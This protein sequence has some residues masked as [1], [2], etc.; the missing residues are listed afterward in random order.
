MNIMITGSNS[1]LGLAMALALEAEGHNVIPF[2]IGGGNDVRRANEKK[3]SGAVSMYGVDSLDVLINNAGVN[4]IAWLEDV[5]DDDWDEVMGVN[6]KGIYKMTQACLPLLKQSKGTVIN[7]VSNA[8]HVPM[9]CSLAYNA[10]KAAAHIMTLQLARELTKKHGITVFGIAPNKLEGTGMSRDIEE[11]VTATRG[12]STAEARQR[13]L[14]ALVTGEETPP[15][16]IAM[17][18]AFLLR[19]KENHKYLSGC[20]LPYGA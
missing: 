17:F 13:Q 9:T 14:D 10:S 8:A 11:Q 2:D 19:S 6:A 18:V 1:G 12:W 7:I 3:A 20:I 16:A 4:R 15:E 5:D